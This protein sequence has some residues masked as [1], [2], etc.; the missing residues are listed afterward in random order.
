[1]KTYQLFLSETHIAPLYVKRD[2][3]NHQ[4]VKD[5]FSSQGLDVLPDLHVTIVFSKRE[6]NWNSIVPDQSIVRLSDDDRTIE[7]FKHTVVMTVESKELQN[8]ARE[9][10]RHGASTDY[11]LYRPHVSISGKLL[12]IKKIRPFTGTVVLGPE[13]FENLKE[14]FESEE[15]FKQQLLGKMASE[16][17][18]VIRKAVARNPNLQPHHLDQ[19]MN[20]SNAWIRAAVAGHPKIQSH[21]MDQLAKG[22]QMH[23]RETVAKHPK[24][25]K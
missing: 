15:Q 4:E 1:M 7:Q 16:S 21:H 2:V 22:A 6:M 9:F 5:W 23:V 3:V 24:R 12:N 13:V 25:N 18:P 8:R 20:D 19:L 10:K 11:D 17:D 14:S